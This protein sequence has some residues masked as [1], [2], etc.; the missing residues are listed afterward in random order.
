[1][2]WEWNFWAVVVS[3]DASLNP[4]LH[5]KKICFRYCVKAIQRTREEPGILKKSQERALGLY[6]YT[7]SSRTFFSPSANSIKNLVLLARDLLII[8]ITS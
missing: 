3:Q 1:M 5:S 7:L 4:H 2:R 8:A 6:V